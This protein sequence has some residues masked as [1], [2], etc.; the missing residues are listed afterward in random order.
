MAELTV[1][2]IIKL[3]LG[4]LVVVAVIG[5]LY[6]IFSGKI[7]GFFRNLPTSEVVGLAGALL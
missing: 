3:I 2:Q 7:L 5:G 6:L 4:I 1:N